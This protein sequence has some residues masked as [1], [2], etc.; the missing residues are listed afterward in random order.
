VAENI[1]VAKA[2]L[3]SLGLRTSR[4]ATALDSCSAIDDLTFG[5]STPVQ[6]AFDELMGKWDRRRASLSESLESV[7][8]AIETITE[9]FETA[10]KALV[11]ALLG[12]E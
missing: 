8:D 1:Y 11:D 6:E 9:A 5:G 10:E 7:T 4:S 2:M 12:D 3:E